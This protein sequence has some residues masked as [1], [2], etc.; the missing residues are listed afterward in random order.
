MKKIVI[1]LVI[2]GWAGGSFAQIK[3]IPVTKT[4]M[5][6]KLYAGML[7]GVNFSVDSLHADA[8]AGVRL[9]S[10]VSWKPSKYIS[11]SAMGMYQLETNNASWTKELFWV[12]VNPLEN[13]TFSFGQMGTLVTEQRPY[14]VSAGGQFETFTEAQIPG[15]A[16]CAKVNWLAI[17]DK[18]SVGAGIAERNGK[19]EYQISI[20]WPK[21][22]T[23]SAFYDEWNKKFGTV[24]NAE[25]WRISEIFVWRQDNVISNLFQLHLGSD[26]SWN[27]YSDT[28]YDLAKKK[29]VR[30]EWGILKE[31][32]GGYI[33]GLIGPG[34]C[35]EDRSIHCYLFIHL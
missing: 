16:L 34:Y 15:A 14:P 3:D 19:P 29:L 4:V 18:L 32:S 12:T 35:Y 2:L 20:S 1:L 23:V 10:S 21:K 7:S 11:V 33:K 5:V 25:F 27:L 30:G 13:L 17:K 22:L 31:F 24:V 28:G 26:R 6:D 8:F 9:G